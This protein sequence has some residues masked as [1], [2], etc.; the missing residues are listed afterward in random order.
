VE[1]TRRET[2]ETVKV[3]IGD[4]VTHVLQALAA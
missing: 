4:V 1:V 3:A 2:G